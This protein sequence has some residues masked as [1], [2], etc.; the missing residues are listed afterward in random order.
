MNCS[1]Q[2]S[3]FN[4]PAAYL[5]LALFCVAIALYN[6]SGTV[7]ESIGRVMPIGF[8]V[9]SAGSFFPNFFDEYGYSYQLHNFSVVV[10]VVAILGVIATTLQGFFSFE[11]LRR[12]RSV[13]LVTVS[14]LVGAFYL[15]LANPPYI[16]SANSRML[17]V[18]A[19]GERPRLCAAYTVLCGV[20]YLFY[21]F[22]V[23]A[24]ALPMLVISLLFSL[25]LLRLGFSDCISLG[26]TVCLALSSQLL[27]FGNVSEG[28]VVNIAVLLFASYAYVKRDWRLFAPSL[29]LVVLARTQYLSV[30]GAFIACEGV[31]FVLEEKR[32][33]GFL[34]LFRDRFVLRS[35]GW[36]FVLFAVWYLLSSSW[37]INMFELLVEGGS[38]E[39]ERYKALPIE[40]FTISP[41]S[42]AYLGH[43]LWSFP[44]VIS[45]LAFLGVFFLFRMNV[46]EL[47]LYLFVVIF[48]F[49][50]ILVHEL[51][52][53]YYYNIRYM[54]YYLPYL[55][56][57]ALITSSVVVKGL[58]LKWILQCLVLGS[59]LTP[60]TS[61]F[62]TK[63]AQEKFAL[64]VLYPYRNELREWADGKL[65]FSNH[66]GMS[67]RNYLAYIFFT[68]ERFRAFTEPEPTEDGIY[69][70][71]AKPQKACRREL[72]VGTLFI[73]DF[74]E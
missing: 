11:F 3:R 70:L 71:K 1:F 5:S 65:V 37:G 66:H 68:F 2:N 46:T 10:F 18:Q 35:L 22:P 58:H 55:V 27:I 32:I 16:W 40:G 44:T 69:V 21:S 56:I 62:E 8:T 19:L 51:L 47:R 60:Y 15:W 64:S 24:V 73:C 20:N 31:A 13:W 23:F 14:L 25:T 49:G 30:L 48:S 50:N 26:A 54:T 59:L 67:S 17:W 61:G 53:L 42:G 6:F 63:R 52:P 57:A 41:L 45:L 72:D 7:A 29:L 38:S 9:R 43:L 39:F 33:F 34:R 36:F 4:L 74:E 28:V 12:Y